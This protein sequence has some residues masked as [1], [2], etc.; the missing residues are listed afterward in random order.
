MKRLLIT[1]MTLSFSLTPLATSAMTFAD[2]ANTPS[3]ALESTASEHT[4][5]GKLKAR[6]AD[7][8]IDT[9][10]GSFSTRSA[11]V[12]DHRPIEDWYKTP[13]DAEVSLYFKGQRLTRVVI[14]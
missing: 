4:V 11:E 1:L 9:S 5:R 6:Y 12:K 13:A 3:P 7:G 2:E 10:E 8:K 14:Y